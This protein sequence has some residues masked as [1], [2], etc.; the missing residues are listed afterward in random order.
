MRIY[1][2]H[3]YTIFPWDVNDET[4]NPYG[5][6]W[7]T[8][9]KGNDKTTRIGFTSLADARNWCKDNY[10]LGVMKGWINA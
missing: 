10:L 1:Y 9:L 4:P 7:Y 3:N 5:Y 2:F 6:K 8:N